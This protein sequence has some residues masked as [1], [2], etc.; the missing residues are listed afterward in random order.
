MIVAIC[1]DD[2]QDAR[3][4]RDCIMSFDSNI[5]IS[6]FSSGEALLSAVEVPRVFDLVFLDIHMPGMNGFEVAKR[7]RTQEHA[8]LVVLVT[9]FNRYVFR[10]YRT[11]WGYIMKPINEKIIHQ[12]LL[13]A[14][15]ELAPQTII[16]DTLEGTQVINAKDILYLEIYQKRGALHTTDSL[17]HFNTSLAEQEKKLPSGM[18]FRPHNSYLVNLGKVKSVTEDYKHIIMQNGDEIALSH[19][20]KKEFYSCLLKFHM[21]D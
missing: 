15:L 2:K 14:Q 7:L 12:H 21:K 6:Q 16:F 17:Y 20:K 1:D 8:P 18:F 3:L 9:R 11:V 13:E 10:G 5:Q 19:K 4:L